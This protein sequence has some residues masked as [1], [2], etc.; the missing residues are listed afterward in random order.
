MHQ[1]HASHRTG[2]GSV[3]G[4]FAGSVHLSTGGKSCHS[5]RAYVCLRLS[6][7]VLILEG[8]AAVPAWAQAEAIIRGQLLA[9]ADASALSGARATL[10][11]ATGES[12]QTA[13]DASG[14]FVFVGVAPGD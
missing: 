4:R 8:F 14:R 11:P 10:R 5:R 2:C 6:A 13:S 12:V 7:C 1:E 9:A 3:L